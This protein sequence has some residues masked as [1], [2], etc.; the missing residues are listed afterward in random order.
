M[1]LRK[2]AGGA[3]GLALAAAVVMYFE[4]N[5]PTGY[6]DPIGI[7]TVCYGHTQGAV[8]GKTLSA[9]ECKRL[10]DRDL[11]IAWTACEKRLGTVPI[12]ILAACTSFTFN[13]G[14]RAMRNSTFASKITAGDYRGGCAELLRWVFAGGR[15]LPGL[16]KRRSIEHQVCIGDGT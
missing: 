11:Q 12:N 8:V 1:I 4:G 2:I 9:A 7:P 5:H 14:E 16:I 3:T 15:A 13:V 10:L 6:L